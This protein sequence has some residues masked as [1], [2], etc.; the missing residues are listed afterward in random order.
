MNSDAGFFQWVGFLIGEYGPMLL[1]GA[2]ITLLI[3]LVGTLA[4]CVIGLL[5]GIV[6]TIPVAPAKSRFQCGLI[7]TIQGLLSAYIE[8]FRGTPMIVQAVVIYYGA[9]QLFQ[10][11]M[12]PLFAG[13]FIVSINTGAYMAETVRGGILAVDPGQMEAGQAIGMSHFQIMRKIILPQALRSILPQICNN[14]IINIKDTAVLS[15]IS[16]TELFYVS[17]TAAGAYYRYFE[18]YFITC[19]MYF[20]MTF[21]LSRL[22]R[23][24]ER[25]L[26]GPENYDLSMKGER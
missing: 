19:V 14:L 26:A 6:H 12:S 2:G 16:V 22:L 9:M 4:G 25:R 5:A 3:A 24:L 18:A 15:V 11:D 10:I 20:V 21:T 13:F 23:R 1:R 7:R 8:I 17:Q